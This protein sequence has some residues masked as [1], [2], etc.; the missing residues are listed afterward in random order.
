MSAT[1]LAIGSAVT[2]STTL[3][4]VCPASIA[5]GNLLLLHIA[6]K[7]P[8]NGPA[9]PSGWTLAGQASG[10][11]GSSGA[12]TG[13]V[14]S[15]VYY[16]IADGT[17]SSTTVTVTLTGVN[18]GVACITRSSVSAGRTPSLV[19]VTGSQNSATAS[20]SVAASGGPG[21][22]GG[23][24]LFVTAAMN[25]NLYSYSAEAITGL[26]PNTMGAE[27][28]RKDS[29][30]GSGDHVG[31][32]VSTHLI[33]SSYGT[34]TPTFT[35]TASGTAANNPCG[36]VVFLR[37]RELYPV[38]TGTPPSFTW[39]PIDGT[40]ALT[41]GATGDLTGG[42][43][44]AGTSAAAFGATGD[45]GGSGALAGTS[46]I[47]FDATGALVG[48]GPLAGTAT[49]AL[50]A[51]G[52]IDGTGA[53]AGTVAAAFGATGALV[54]GGPL[55][56]TSV[57]T[58][59]TSGTVHWD[60]AIAGTI[61]LTFGA[62]GAVT[63][64]GPLAGVAAL[65]IGG[66]G[67]ALGHAAI[68]GTIVLTFGAR[69]GLVR[70]HVDTIDRPGVVSRFRDSFR[71][72][73][74]KWLSD[75]PG[76]RNG[77]TVGYR[78]LWSMISTFD[79][80]A[81]AGVQALQAPWPGHGTP[82]ALPY[83]GRSRGMIRAQN[84]ADAEYAARML[85]W[86][87]RARQLGSML[88]TSRAIHEYLANRP[89]VRIYNRAGACVEVAETTGDVTS[90]APGTT[91]WDWDSVSNPERAAYWW[92]L[93]LCVYPMQW[94]GAPALQPGSRRLAGTHTA[95]IGS[96]ATRE[97]HDAIVGLIEQH[98]SAH[99]HMRAVIFTTDETLF[100]PNDPTTQPD[101]EWG[102]WSGRG[103][104]SRTVSH[105]NVTDCRYLEL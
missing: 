12:D 103:S 31:L 78:Y 75:R 30:S 83:I 50:D 33:G 48:G 72:Y 17:E 67:L 14:Y 16:K 100:D 23:D 102:D 20:W 64:R 40:A 104:G 22:L 69:G 39:G 25:T 81:E 32:M 61:A 2:G 5:A 93:W 88:S 53:L 55:A 42:G 52:A 73:T 3:S 80:A 49:I 63:G 97:E 51:T 57:V 46:S 90:Y 4:P 28:E 79:E 27:T 86:L 84:E 29:G 101:G 77:K 65:A 56:G 9:A 85:P 71:A 13:S 91:S 8:T 105:R 74:V 87:D 26:S 76:Q 47:A 70:T 59:G 92:D 15:T 99:S 45:L 82:S 24:V 18:Q 44:L 38:T 11:S 96:T 37:F 10:G 43:P 94:S 36:A 6:S 19:A 58:F 1:F 62:T 41:F 66:H 7:Y 34:A 89:R 21:T 35:M 54:G 98:K 60:A 95:T 68:A